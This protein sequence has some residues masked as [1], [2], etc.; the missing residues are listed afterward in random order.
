MASGFITSD[1]PKI[2][3]L[4]VLWGGT[5]SQQYDVCPPDRTQA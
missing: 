4:L 3:G 1:L 2:I 5:P